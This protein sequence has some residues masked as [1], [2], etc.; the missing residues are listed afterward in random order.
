MN[1][2][3]LLLFGTVTAFTIVFA[4]PIAD[5][6]DTTPVVDPLNPKGNLIFDQNITLSKYSAPAGY[7][8]R[9]AYTF[10]DG[11]VG[12]FATDVLERPSLPKGGELGNVAPE[13]L[14]IKPPQDILN[15]FSKEGTLLETIKIPTLIEHPYQGNGPN[16]ITRNSIGT[17]WAI[18][19]GSIEDLIGTPRGAAV[20]NLLSHELVSFDGSEMKKIVDLQSFF[21]NSLPVAGSLTMSGD[22]LYV[23]ATVADT[24]YV[25]ALDSRDGTLKG[26]SKIDQ[27]AGFQLLPAEGGKLAFF[28]RKNG[29]LNVYTLSLP[30][31]L[32]PDQ[33]EQKILPAALISQSAPD[34]NARMSLLASGDYAYDFS[35]MMVVMDPQLHFVRTEV[36]RSS[37]GTPECTGCRQ[38]RFPM[39]LDSE[40]QLLVT[41]SEVLVQKLKPIH[42]EVDGKLLVTDSP[43]YY[44]TED[45]HVWVPL[46]AAADAVGAKV[47]YIPE[48]RT[49]MLAYAGRTIEISQDNPQIEMKTMLNYGH[50]Y[51]GLRAL[52]NLLGVDV[53]WDQENYTVIVSNSQKKTANFRNLFVIP[54]PIKE[55][56][57]S[58]L[59]AP[60][61][62]ETYFYDSGKTYVLMKSPDGKSEVNVVALHQNGDQVT[63]DYF[64]GSSR[65]DVSTGFYAL[66]E[67]D[68]EVKVVFN[69]TDFTARAASRTYLDQNQAIEIAKRYDANPD[70][71]WSAR[72]VEDTKMEVNNADTPYSIWITEA[73]YPAGNKLIVYLDAVT[74][75]EIAMT[76]TEVPGLIYEN[77]NNHFSIELPRSW[78]GKYLV[79]EHG[80]DRGVEP[81][82]NMDFI[83]AA[84]KEKYGGLLFTI[85]VWTKEKWQTEGQTLKGII[86]NH[87]TKIGETREKVVLLLTPTDVQ[88]SLDDKMLADDY[89]N[90]FNDIEYIKNTFWTNH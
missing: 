82:D 14:W 41:E 52:S 68:Q 34:N 60:E 35:G 47:E 40:K 21:P 62:V 37:L 27:N 61:R 74:G 88:F 50:V 6:A 56:V 23:T 13:H 48:T 76:E 32:S 26:K 9:S 75:R 18:R 28:N 67:F 89:Q 31:S 12:V 49:I 71:K 38:I 29:E 2:I 81:G 57:S 45:G 7:T 11:S 70:T 10:T 39:L 59:Q 3:R 46:R 84:N 83:N 72:L 78:K 66:G 80:K 77:T 51:V 4:T 17:Y 16:S 22:T 53:S 43:V 79:E 25:L 85:N 63:V 90:M 15:R 87:L 86:G 20:R 65:T 30:E 58:Q 5:A 64:I 42:A 55:R 33:S 73:V 54:E 69:S 24:F 44:D 19:Q 8:F 1:I 36:L